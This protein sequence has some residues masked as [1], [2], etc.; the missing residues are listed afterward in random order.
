MSDEKKAHDS[1][2]A[3]AGSVKSKPV[4]YSSD[5][6][7]KQYQRRNRA[8]G[9]EIIMLVL[10][11]R[12]VQLYMVLG[13]DC[14]QDGKAEDDDDCALWYGTL[15]SSAV[16]VLVYFLYILCRY[17]IGRLHQ[18]SPKADS[19]ES[20]KLDLMSLAFLAMPLDS[21]LAVVDIGPLAFLLV[22]GITGCSMMFLLSWCI[23]TD[24]RTVAALLLVVCFDGVA[25]T[26][27][28]WRLDIDPDADWLVTVRLQNRSLSVLCLATML[29]PTALLL[30]QGAAVI[31]GCLYAHQGDDAERATT[32]D[33]DNQT[34]PVPLTSPYVSESSEQDTSP[35]DEAM[36][37]LDTL[38][39]HAQDKDHAGPKAPRHR[40]NAE[41]EVFDESPYPEMGSAYCEALDR[42]GWGDACER[43]DTMQHLGDLHPSAFCV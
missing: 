22:L 14:P 27:M 15:Y 34:R 13:E 26:L 36:Q 32:I 2:E 16:V 25:Y 31:A 7:E 4:S 12:L 9:V 18:A 35:L 11:A 3:P 23:G 33:L 29:V 43:L 10:L 17:A 40:R 28:A 1:V 30:K 19:L 38:S 6:K 37:A 42:Q 41:P 8:H 20:L 5:E 39:E 21:A 24:N